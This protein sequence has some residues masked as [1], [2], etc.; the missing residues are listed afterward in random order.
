MKKV[1]PTDRPSKFHNPVKFDK[2]SRTIKKNARKQAQK[3]SKA[4]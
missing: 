1:R 2:K 4:R 3:A